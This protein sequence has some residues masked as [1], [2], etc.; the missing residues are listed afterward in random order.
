VERVEEWSH[1]SYRLYLR[2]SAEPVTM[3]RRHAGRLKR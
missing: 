1:S 2:Y 3:S